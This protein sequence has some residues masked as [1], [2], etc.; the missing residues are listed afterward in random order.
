MSS[1]G[2]GDWALVSCPDFVQIVIRYPDF[3]PSLTDEDDLHGVPM[4]SGMTQEDRGL[5]LVFDAVVV[6]RTP[7]LA[8][9]ER[10]GNCEKWTEGGDDVWHNGYQY[11]GNMM[12]FFGFKEY[13][14]TGFSATG[15]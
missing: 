3:F 14:Y 6:G 8:G 5:R 1:F 13:A 7:E 12:G 2:A 10:S 11:G 4:G 9:S 15:V